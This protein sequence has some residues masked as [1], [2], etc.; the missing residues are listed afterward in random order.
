MTQEVLVTIPEYYK[1]FNYLKG[2]QKGEIDKEY[3]SKVGKA[4]LY[5]YQD[6]PCRDEDC[7][8]INFDK[9]LG[10]RWIPNSWIKPKSIK[11]SE[12]FMKLIE[13]LYT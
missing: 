13:R 8:V 11:T 5:G 9:D 1:P 2:V 6:Y 7:T 10:R 4:Y 3:L 12:E